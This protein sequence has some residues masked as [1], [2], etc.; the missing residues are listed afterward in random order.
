MTN[1]A[2]VKKDR[3]R[4]AQVRALQT[5]TVSPAGDALSWP[6]LDIDA[7]VPGLVERAFGT[8]LFAPATGQRGGQGR[9]KSQGRTGPR[10]RRQA[11]ST[12]KASHRVVVESPIMKP[13]PDEKKLLRSFERGEWKPTSADEAT[14][15]R[16]LARQH[17][18]A[19]V[20]A[21]FDAID[22]GAGRSYDRVSGRR[23]AASI[24]SRGRARRTKRR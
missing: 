15:M 21:G 6:A 17:L 22:R 10:E 19:D 14:R 16:E 8:R 9:S 7:Y 2:I 24:T 20:Q 12:A 11:W 13:D 23:L 3:Q 5:I 18:R 4:L 1:R